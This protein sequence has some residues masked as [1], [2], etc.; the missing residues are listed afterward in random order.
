MNDGERDEL[1]IELRTELKEARNDIKVVAKKLYGNGQQGLVSEVTKNST[2]I[3][4]VKW[5]IGVGFT[6]LACLIAFFNI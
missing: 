2:T 6:A 1:L 3:K 4:N 5:S